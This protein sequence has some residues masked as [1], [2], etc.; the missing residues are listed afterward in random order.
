MCN[1]ICPV[2]GENQW[3][4]FLKI[5]TGSI[6][7]GDQRIIQGKLEKILC[8]KCTLVTNADRFTNND[9]KRLYG[10]EYILNTLGKEEHRFFIQSGAIPRSKVFFDWI[11]PWLP[12]NFKSFLEIGC[13]EGNLLTRFRDEFKKRKIMGIE[14]SEKACELAAKKGLD[15]SCQMILSEKDQIPEV[16]V[17][18]S[19]A[20][21]EHAEDIKSFISVLKKSVKNGGRIIFC[22]PVQNY[23][24][25]DIFFAEH[26]WHMTTFHFKALFEQNGLKCIHVDDAHP[27]N[28]GIGLFVCEKDET[29]F[30]REDFLKHLSSKPCF[31]KQSRDKWLGVFNKIDQWIKDKGVSKIAVFG[32]GEVA[33]LFLA[34]TKI[35]NIDVA[36]FID[37]D[38]AKI[39][40]E[41][42]GVPVFGVDWLEPGKVDAVLLAVNPRYHEVVRKKLE[43]KNID[44][45]VI[46]DK[47]KK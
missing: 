34:F 30:L 31:V 21:I 40:S 17:L 42:H 32:S 8:S 28:P 19:V 35:S 47:E 14:G 36:A 46:W 11:K 27:V 33:T 39:G 43:I 3:E 12:K 5:D 16:D 37:E 24:G 23:P 13:G 45:G 44:L 10:K 2:C 25:Y 6:I 4:P 7:T 1:K 41:K 18:L 20:V 22:V 29:A 38:S 15:V 9:L 26:V